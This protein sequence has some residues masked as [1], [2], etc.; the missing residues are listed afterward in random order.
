MNKTLSKIGSAVVTV[1]VFLF[2]L[3]IIMQF[4]FGSYFVCMFLP[5]G[6]MMTAAGFVYDAGINQ[7]RR[8]G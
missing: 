8:K 2:A 5:I 6:Y 3:F 1:T 7:F 4:T